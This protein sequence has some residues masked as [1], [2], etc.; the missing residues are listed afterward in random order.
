MI[1]RI[2]T[3]YMLLAALLCGLMFL[4]PLMWFVSG[5]EQITLGTCFLT[6]GEEAVGD[7]PLYFTLLVGASALL[8]FVTIFLYKRRLLQIRLCAVEAVLL[9]GVL[10]MEA[11]L[12][13]GPQEL[14]RGGL[15]PASFIPVAA[16]F[17]TWLAARATFKDEMLVRSLSR[18]R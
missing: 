15:M 1:Q 12:Y 16:L 13:W 3:V 2:Q 11:L 14:Q 9:F 5:A 7:T 6:Q 8:P 10:A 4:F 17:L 18:I